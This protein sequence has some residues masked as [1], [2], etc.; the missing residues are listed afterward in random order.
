MRVCYCVIYFLVLI[1]E[2]KGD[3]VLGGKTNRR[4]LLPVR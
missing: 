1:G 3:G 2:E 4:E